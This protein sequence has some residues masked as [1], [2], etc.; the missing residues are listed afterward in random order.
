MGKKKWL[1]P[2]AIAAVLTAALAVPLLSVGAPLSQAIETIDVT[3]TPTPSPTPVP[4]QGESSNDVGVGKDVYTVDEIVYAYGSGFADNDFVDVYI[5]RD[6]TWNNGDTISGPYYG[7]TPKTV[8]ADGDGIL[9]PANVW[10]P[11]LT[12]GDYDMVFDANQD[13][14]Y[15][16]PGDVV[17]GPNP[18][19]FRVDGPVGGIVEPVDPSEQGATSGESLDGAS[20][21]TFVAL[22]IGVAV[23]FAAFLVWSLRRRRVI[24]AGKSQ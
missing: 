4:P 21:T 3:P 15:N 6:R 17:D 13:G 2:L 12:P 5:V 7:D 11:P 20:T 22:G 14:F 19:G 1:I 24:G 10:S 9:G 23:L 8:Q 16:P 18:P